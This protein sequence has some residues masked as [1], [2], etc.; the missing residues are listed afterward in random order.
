MMNILTLKIAKTQLSLESQKQSHTI[1]KEKYL[2]RKSDA[3]GGKNRLNFY[4][5][6]D[7]C[8]KVALIETN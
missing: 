6:S 7:D 4:F 2:E 3:D 1:Q 8:P 5:S